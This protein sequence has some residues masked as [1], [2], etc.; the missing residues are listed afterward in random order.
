[1]QHDDEKTGAEIQDGIEYN[2]KEEEVELAEQKELTLEETLEQDRQ[3]ILDQLEASNIFTQLINT[4]YSFEQ[5]ENITSSDSIPEDF[6][7]TELVRYLY[8]SSEDADICRH[9]LY[10]FEML[11]RLS[12]FS[13]L[14]SSEPLSM[15]DYID[16]ISE[17]LVE[18]AIEAASNEQFEVLDL[19]R[20]RH[21]QVIW[22]R[23]FDILDSIPE[24]TSP[25]E[26]TQFLPRLDV[27]HGGNEIRW[28][29]EPWRPLDW[30]ERPEIKEALIGQDIDE[31]PGVLLPLTTSDLTAWYR[32]RARD[33]EIS[34]GQLEQAHELLD[35][36]I[37]HGAFGLEAMAEQTSLFSTLVYNVHTETVDGLDVMDL[38]AFEQ[39]D[40]AQVV[41]SILNGCTADTI[42]HE[43]RS[44]VLP[45]LADMPKRNAAAARS[46]Q[47]PL[48]ILYDYILTIPD[49][50]TLL[51]IFLASRPDRNGTD[52]IVASDHDLARMI[53][54]VLYADKSS[55]SW[56]IYNDIFD[57]LPSLEGTN[58][59]TDN[60]I[61]L[62]RSVMSAAD[63]YKEFGRLDGPALVHAMDILEA[64][65]QAGEIFD[66]WESPTT[67]LSLASSEHTREAQERLCLRAIR[68]ASGGVET[69]G[70][71]MTREREWFS[72]LQDLQK[73]RE[74]INSAPGVLNLVSSEE[75]SKWIVEALLSCGRFNLAKEIFV[76]PKKKIGIP[77]GQAEQLVIASAREFYDNAESGN[78]S[79]GEMKMAYDCLHILPPS[80]ELKKEL[81]LIEGTNI[82]SELRLTG[83]RE[84]AVLPFQIRHHKNR[85]ELVQRAVSSSSDAYRKTAVMLNLSHKLGF[86]DT[87]SDCKVLAMCADAAIAEEDYET[88]YDLCGRCI[89]IVNTLQKKKRKGDVNADAAAN[90]TWRACFTTCRHGPDED[91][92]NH[93]QTLERRMH[94]LGQALAL[95]TDRGDVASDAPVGT[96]MSDVLQVYRTVEA[97]YIRV[98]DSLD[99]SKRSKLPSAATVAA[100]SLSQIARGDL[101]R[102]SASTTRFAA[103]A[104]SRVVGSSHA[105]TAHWGKPRLSGESQRSASGERPASPFKGAA[106]AA[107]AASN[108]GMSML[109]AL[110]PESQT[111]L[112]RT[113]KRDAIKT[114]FNSG[115][116]S[117]VS[118]LLGVDAPPDGSSDKE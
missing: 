81:D 61:D 48:S 105:P 44:H 24:T 70:S 55:D 78:M 85:L 91:S 64:H 45:Y 95:C 51:N 27:T 106:G 7:S 46:I 92:S 11:D 25:M 68:Q 117:G 17:D 40:D 104:L 42:V 20:R 76:D 59:N 73:L 57:C 109:G 113:R 74:S 33:I 115:L 6:D 23:R 75:I 14:L 100:D 36:G 22:P 102:V 16:F 58:A 107:S 31:H 63:L 77:F 8:T 30:V 67:L 5:A 54:A 111:E 26:Y 49:L 9:R 50:P 89:K 35:E 96:L 15:D 1:M 82:L 93:F 47:D 60:E 28:P 112:E 52:R 41:A 116:T 18:N 69:G 84:G 110:Q 21:H 32:R 99:R 2:E 29:D 10:L 56:S 80:A 65:L 83:T 38:Q 118:W 12:T 19:L 88:A 53:L 90:V 37:K 114:A 97:E 71:K 72:L 34:T 94:L 66:K 87:V 3:G 43:I 79:K 108:W 13:E 62:T 39:L 98:Y 103:N 86:P 101:S 4:C